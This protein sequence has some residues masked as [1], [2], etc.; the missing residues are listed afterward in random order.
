LGPGDLELLRLEIETIWNVDPRGRVNGPDLVLA[1][2]T[3]GL[4]VAFGTAVPDTLAAALTEAVE[5]AI[6]P[7]DLRSPPGVLARCR[8]LL[9]QTFAPAEVALACGPSYLVPDTVAFASEITVVRSDAS[10]LSAVREANPG[11]WQAD[12]WQDLLDGHLGPWVMA[13]DAGQV[14]SICHTPVRTP[15]SAEAGTWTKP[16]YR[17]QG[18]AAA[19][20]AAWARLVR[21][22]GRHLFYSTSDWNT[23]SQAVA[24]RLSLRPIGWLWQL[25]RR[26]GP[27]L[28]EP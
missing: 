24:A 6:P 15:R 13:L 2:A 26:N 4:G 12:E 20:T 25:A 21:P 22:T 18:Y 14:V 1:S 7:G 27:I 8:A 28:L 10:D 23:S 9:E 5:G 3:S 11:N 16:G 17:G 19:T